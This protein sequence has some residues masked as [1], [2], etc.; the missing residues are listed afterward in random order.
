MTKKFVDILT[1]TE[2][3][4]M[5]DNN[6]LV[7]LSTAKLEALEQRWV[8]RLSKFNFKIQMPSP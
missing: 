6:P 5:T 7:Y 1:G 2:F 8:A 3:L 4:L